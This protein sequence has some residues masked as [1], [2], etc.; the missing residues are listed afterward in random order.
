M[1]NASVRYGQRPR[2]RFCRHRVEFFAESRPD[3]VAPPAGLPRWGAVPQ[4]ARCSCCGVEWAVGR[5][6]DRVVG[7]RIAGQ[8]RWCGCED[9]D[10][11][12]GGF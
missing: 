2:G 5:Q 12:E 6:G 1:E 10:E 9:D 4:R 11:E 8:G 7:W 3:V